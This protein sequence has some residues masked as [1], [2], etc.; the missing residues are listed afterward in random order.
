M[1]SRISKHEPLLR[2]PDGVPGLPG[3]DSPSWTGLGGTLLLIHAILAMTA[4]L[5]RRSWP[6]FDGLVGDSTL[7]AYV[8]SG[9]IM[10]G[11]LIFL[12]TLLIIITRRV[13]SGDIL[14]GKAKAGSLILSL[15]AGIPAAVVFQGLNNLLIYGLVRSGI[16]LPA[17]SAAFDAGSSLFSRPLP[18]LLLIIMISVLIPSLVE[19]LMFR[20]VI[21]ASLT[22]GGATASAIILQAAAFAVFHGEPLFILPPFLAALLLALIRRNSDSLLPAILMH[23]SLNFSLLALAPLLPTLTVD[24]LSTGGNES[25]SLLYASLIAAFVAAVALVPLIVLITSQ[26]ARRPAHARLHFWPADWKFALAFL[27]LIATMIVEF[28]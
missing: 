18:V 23:I 9:L 22:S 17:A 8:L 21:L 13:S 24:Y 5:L 4:V 3:P 11:G 2:Q 20:G 26:P 19:E 10:Q 1:K 28:N 27:L 25:L 7:N 16:R 6:P 12:P 14:G 15:T